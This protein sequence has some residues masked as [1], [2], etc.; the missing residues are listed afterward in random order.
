LSTEHL[1][2]FDFEERKHKDA[3]TYQ[4]IFSGE[5]VQVIPGQ[6]N[7]YDDEDIDECN[8]EIKTRMCSPKELNDP[9]NKYVLLTAFNDGLHNDLDEKYRK[10]FLKRIR[11]IKKDI[12]TTPQPPPQKIVQKEAEKGRK[13]IK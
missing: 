3:E 7:W 12:A 9:E 6:K 2:H 4:K 10:P 11:K 8:A 1:T 5:E 13:I